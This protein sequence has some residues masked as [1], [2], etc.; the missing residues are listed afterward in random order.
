MVSLNQRPDFNV[1]GQWDVETE[2]AEGQREIH[3]FDAVMVCTGH[4][5]QPHLP[6]SHFPGNR[7]LATLIPL[8][9]S[10]TH[11]SCCCLH[12]LHEIQGIE[13]FK[14]RYFHSWE[15]RTAKDLEGKR[16]VVVGTG[17]SGCDIAVDISRVAE[18]VN[19]TSVFGPN[20][21]MVMF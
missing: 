11:W 15:Y 21:T 6:L 5:T 17:N 16:V 9:V 12:F 2:T 7:L 20:L 4:Y 10:G 14:G 19:H 3:I 1:M 13:S 18:K 8:L